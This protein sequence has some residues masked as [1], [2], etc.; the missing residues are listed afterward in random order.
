MH[1]FN[2]GLQ[3]RTCLGLNPVDRKYYASEYETLY[4]IGVSGGGRNPV[5]ES[6]FNELKQAGSYGNQFGIESQ[7]GSYLN[8]PLTSGETGNVLGNAGMPGGGGSLL[9][10]AEAL[11]QFNIRST[12]PSRTALEASKNPLRDRYNNLLT[13]LTRRENVETGQTNTAL[14]REYGKRGIPLS[15]GAFEQ[16]LLGKTQGIS[17]YYGGQRGGV[18]N[19]LSQQESGINLAIADLLSG[20]PEA[21]VQS[22]LSALAQ[23]EAQRQNAI[24]NA[25]SQ[26]E[27]QLSQQTADRNYEISKQ[28][29]ASKNY[30]TVPE[31]NSVFDLST[32]Q[33]IFNNPKTYKGTSGSDDSY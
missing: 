8:N 12:E 18:A 28:T 5:Q 23:Q 33:S 20:N 16:D 26:R 22:A 10:Q 29:D 13:E 25:L 24:Q 4:N 21:S 3:F 6:R 14:S 17:Q 27:F 9:D 31:G 19:D 7:S 1:N 2:K 15:S 11:R 30:L 32:L